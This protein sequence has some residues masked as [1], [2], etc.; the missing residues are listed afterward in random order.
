MRKFEK[1]T[2]FLDNEEFIQWRLTGDETLANFWNDFLQKYPESK[3]S[4]YCAIDYFSKI[5]LNKVSLSEEEK[6]SLQN[7]IFTT[8]N[9]IQKKRKLSRF[10]Y[11]GTAA[12]ISLLLGLAYWNHSTLTSPNDTLR[13]SPTA[14]IIG[15][16]L[17][18]QDICLISGSKTSSFN[19]D[20]DVQVHRDGQATVIDGNKKKSKIEISKSTTNKL[21]VPF[22]KRSKVTLEDGT[23]IW[24]NSGS[25]FE[26]PTTFSKSCREVYLTGEMYAE[27]KRDEAKP[28]IVHTNK[29][30]I[31]VYGTKFNISAY[32]DNQIPSAC[33]L[34]EGSVGI[35]SQ[36]TPEI[37]MK[38][39]DMVI[40]QNHQFT[41]KQVDVS[42]YISWKDG[43]LEFD[44]T[45]IIEVLE[46]IGRYYNLS[47]DFGDKTALQ[48]RTCSGKIYLSENIEN[49]LETISLLS[50]AEYKKENQT[51]LITV[52]PKN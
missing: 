11:W 29:F 47:F 31:R 2:D 9:K 14:L 16:A 30:N 36:D 34:V 26:F 15:Q 51:I 13:T 19:Q 48:E 5:K 21:V 20:V 35:Q 42:K 8:V 46:K 41:K 32:G 52:N 49:V 17:K 39:N 3:E 38:K 27:V 44:N 33:V 18:S 6:L 43:Y 7:R 10:I 22:G 28:F 4:F 45:S 50:S 25:I 23:T 12:S 37:K 40:C 1:Y 24:L